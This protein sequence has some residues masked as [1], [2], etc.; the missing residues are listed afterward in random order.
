[1]TTPERRALTGEGAAGW[2]SGSQK[3]KGATAA[4]TARPP[5]TN[6][7]AATDHVS[8]DAAPEA[9]DAPHP[10]EGE[11]ARE[12]VEERDA[13]EESRRTGRAHDQVLQR[14]LDGLPL[15][16]VEGDEKVGAEAHHLPVNEEGDR[17]AG[18]EDAQH[19]YRE[20]EQQREVLGVA[21]ADVTCG[22]DRGEDEDRQ[23]HER[24]EVGQLVDHDDRAGNARF[25][26]EGRAVSVQELDER[27]VEGS[28]ERDRGGHR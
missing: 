2:A 14:R 9:R 13:E 7:K 20:D 1:M 26:T 8:L 6:A 28:D 17:V 3:W 18:I 12:A 21:L 5:M 19:P 15:P 25:R 16:V 27:D 23:D 4:F 24:D 22:V 11:V 10:C